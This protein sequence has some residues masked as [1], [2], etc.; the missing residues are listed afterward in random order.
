[1]SDNEK[2]MRCCDNLLKLV[3]TI[4]PKREPDGE[5]LEHAVWMLC[6]IKGGSITGAGKC[7]RWLG[8]VMAL[9]VIH[10]VT[11]LKTVRQIVDMSFHQ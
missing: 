1:M 10:E 6:Q 9:F 11:S 8:Y 3:G 4:V 5:T 2:I 7:N